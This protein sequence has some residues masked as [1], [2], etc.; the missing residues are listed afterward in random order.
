M[1]GHGR[2]AG[3]WQG[4]RA[5]RP[6][7][8]LLPVPCPM[9][10]GAGATVVTSRPLISDHARPAKKTEETC[11]YATDSRPDEQKYFERAAEAWGRMCGP[12]VYTK[13]SQQSICL[14]RLNS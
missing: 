4:G 12:C 6:R 13:M 8:D 14:V 5:P 1:A 3:A 10:D 2:S 7:A 9:C 11:V